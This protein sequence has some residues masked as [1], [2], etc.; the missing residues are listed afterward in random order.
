VL[1]V[2]GSREYYLYYYAPLL[3]TAIEK[4]IGEKTMWQWLSAMAK[5]RND[6]ADYSFL[7][8]SFK[9]SV[10]DPSLQEKILTKYF[11]SPDALQ[12]AKDELG[13]N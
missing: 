6:H 10:T 5:S 4:E 9:R 13:L 1:F 3:L 12:N 11:Q 2:N 7:A 8:E